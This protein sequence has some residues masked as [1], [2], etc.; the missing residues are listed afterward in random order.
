MISRKRILIHNSSLD[1][2]LILI[3]HVLFI[4]KISKT[5]ACP[6]LVKYSPEVRLKKAKVLD[7]FNTDKYVL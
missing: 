5:L 7:I 3:K 1:S 4:L 2:I 6:Y